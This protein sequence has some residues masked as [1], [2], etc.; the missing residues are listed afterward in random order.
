MNQEAKVWSMSIFDDTLHS[1]KKTMEFTIHLTSDEVKKIEEA[2][3]VADEL[4][5]SAV[6]NAIIEKILKNA[7]IVLEIKAQV[8]GTYPKKELVVAQKF[9]IET[10]SGEIFD[11]YKSGKTS[12]IDCWV[13]RS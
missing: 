7:G 3:R 11:A 5:D 12:D 6:E 8:R 10:P 2:G 9:G 13:F 1:R 4:Y